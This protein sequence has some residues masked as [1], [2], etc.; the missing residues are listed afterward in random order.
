VDVW[1]SGSVRAVGLGGRVQWM[2]VPSKAEACFII[3]II[4]YVW[5]RQQ[6]ARATFVLCD[7][8]I[9]LASLLWLL[10]IG[11]LLPCIR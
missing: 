5:C 9:E 10:M 2:C 7:T 8:V 4:K 11:C 6:L 1:A 3:N